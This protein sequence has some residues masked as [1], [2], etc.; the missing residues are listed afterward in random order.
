MPAAILGKKVGMTQ[1]YTEDGRLRPVTVIQ[2]GPCVV[3]Q[4]KTVE[5]PPGKVRGD[6]YYAL[7]L[8]FDDKPLRRTTL[9][10]QGH[11]AKAGTTP[12]RF[13]REIRLKTKPEAAAGSTVTVEAFA[14]VGFVDITGRSKGKG[15]QGV[16][17]RHHF[18]GQPASHGTERK[19]RS[20]GSIGGMAPGAPGRGIKKGK[21]MPGH[22]GDERVTSRN[23]EVIRVDAANH[24]LVVA[25]SVP[26]A[27]DGYLFI[28]ESKTRPGPKPPPRKPEEGKK[29]G[30]LPGKK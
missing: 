30:A 7:Q 6:G 8:G 12:K 21:R 4:V 13:I 2:A 9:P 24:V 1:V 17:K 5:P 14:G 18:G 16:M 27:R 11:A 29:K 23:H 22:M 28:R 10:A 26:G 20:P 3:M 19:H 25:G 15:F